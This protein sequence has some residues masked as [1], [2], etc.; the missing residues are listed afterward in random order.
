MTSCHGIQEI[1]FLDVFLLWTVQSLG[2]GITIAQPK[3][4]HEL[5]LTRIR[6]RLRKLF[7]GCFTP[8]VYPAPKDHTNVL[9]V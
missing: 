6:G 5:L 8:E 1:L 9:F 2:G 7:S 4:G 3:W